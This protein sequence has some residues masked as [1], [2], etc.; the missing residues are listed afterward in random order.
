[1]GGSPSTAGT[2]VANRSGVASTSVRRPDLDALCD[3]ARR[4]TN[5]ARVASAASKWG[6][7]DVDVVLD[8]VE[9]DVLI[10]LAEAFPAVART[11]SP[12]DEAALR[13]VIRATA[14]PHL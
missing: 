5:P 12:E 8:E 13:A 9:L 11:P 4:L 14:A 1:M 10:D 2:R 6:R 3:W 7:H